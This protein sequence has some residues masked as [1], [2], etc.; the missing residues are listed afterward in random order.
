[1]LPYSWAGCGLPRFYRPLNHRQV[2]DTDCV[3]FFDTQVRVEQKWPRVRVD[4]VQICV[5]C[6]HSRYNWPDHTQQQ[7]LT[8]TMR[9]KV[10]H[11]H[12][13]ITGRV[14]QNQ[15]CTRVQGVIVRIFSTRTRA[16][17]WIGCACACMHACT[18]HAR[19][20]L[21][22]PTVLGPTA[23]ICI[24]ITITRGK[25]TLHPVLLHPCARACTASSAAASENTDNYTACK[26]GAKNC[27]RVVPM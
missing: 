22:C 10:V 23:H 26:H 14:I 9:V 15:T 17:N 27:K 20:L 11:A 13:Q 16:H 5:S 2:S 4:K 18:H 21:Y 6:T 1:M 12:A 3:L 25:C 24:Q 19:E 7:H 8:L